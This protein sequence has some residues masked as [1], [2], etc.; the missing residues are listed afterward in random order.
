VS[1]IL[2]QLNIS[3]YILQSLATRSDQVEFWIGEK[4]RG[5][6]IDLQLRNCI[7][8]PQVTLN[9]MPDRK[10]R[11][12]PRKEVAEIAPLAPAPSIPVRPCVQSTLNITTPAFVPLPELN[13]NG[14]NNQDVIINCE[15]IASPNVQ[16]CRNQTEKSGTQTKSP[17]SLVSSSSSPILMVEEVKEDFSDV[18][19]LKLKEVLDE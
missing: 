5:V 12:R 2:A 8:R 3:E 16:I 7:S 13:L 19:G 1:D 6:S 10:P 11:G 14:T 15:D 18:D 4:V 17:S 9:I